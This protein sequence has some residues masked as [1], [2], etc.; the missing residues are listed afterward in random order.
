ML[1]LN[2]AVPKFV[3]VFGAIGAAIEGAVKEYAE[4][5]RARRFP[6]AEHTYAMKKPAKG[7]QGSGTVR[8]TKKPKMGGR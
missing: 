3:K 8:A 1:G 6:A 2:P 7:G 5:V 4:E